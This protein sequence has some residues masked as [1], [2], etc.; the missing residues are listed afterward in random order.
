MNKSETLGIELNLSPSFTFIHE[1]LRNSLLIN[2]HNRY[3]ILYRYL[4]VRQISKDV[5]YRDEAKEL[6]KMKYQ[7][8]F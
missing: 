1:N 3:K 7:N 4:I 8:Q 6:K 2:S 5:L